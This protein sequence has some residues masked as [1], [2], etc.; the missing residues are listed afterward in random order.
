MNDYVS[1]PVRPGE[2]FAAIERVI[3]KFPPC[4]PAKAAATDAVAIPLR[5]HLNRRLRRTPSPP[6]LCWIR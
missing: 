1:K 4:P 6:P 2:L 5:P 3:A